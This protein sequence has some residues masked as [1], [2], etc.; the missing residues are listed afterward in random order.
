MSDISS[1]LELTT[2]ET[3]FAHVELP[4]DAPPRLVVQL[5]GAKELIDPLALCSNEQAFH[6]VVALAVSL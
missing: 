3:G 1:P 4:L 2:W 6:F 5:A